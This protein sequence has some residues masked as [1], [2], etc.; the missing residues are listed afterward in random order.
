ML[1]QICCVTHHARNQ[2]LAVRKR[3]L[4]PDAP[5]VF[6]P[7][8]TGLYR[9]CARVYAQHQIDDVF[10]GNVGGMWTMPTAPADVIT[11]AIHGQPS[12]S[13]VESFNSDAFEFL[14]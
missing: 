8:I 4:L 5:L 1:D 6:V 3:H 7:H 13:P 12:Q 10:Q 9:I 11:D 14:E 2:A